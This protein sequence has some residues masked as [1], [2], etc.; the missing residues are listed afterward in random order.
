MYLGVDIGGTKTLVA[1]LDDEANIQEQ[2]KFPTPKNYDHWLLELRHTLH[3]FEHQDFRAAGVA[4]PGRLNR[5]HGIVYDLGNLPWHDERIQADCEKIMA[6]PV[7]IEND[8]N[9][10][11][12]SEAMLHKDAETVLYITV[13]TGIGTGVVYKQQLDPALLD[14]EGGHIMVPHRGRLE[15]W[16]SFASGRAIYRHF[17]K[18]A[19]DITDEADWRLIAH[20]LAVGLF[21]HLA[22]VQPDLIIIGGSVGVHFTHYAKFLEAELK[23]YEVPLVPVPPIVPADRPELAVVYG[24][25]DLAKQR[26]PAHGHAAQP[27]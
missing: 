21:E 3:H 7:V 9:L 5:E 1:V 8:A 16:E 15:E 27:A 25:Y 6:C 24:C 4:V 22:I 12:L 19:A 20:N 13:S 23:K 26:Y 18:K 10:A 17:G 14:S 11:G 2:A